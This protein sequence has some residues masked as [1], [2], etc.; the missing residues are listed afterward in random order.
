MAA[1]AHLGIG[2]AAKPLAPKVSLWVLLVA[3]ELLDILWLAFYFTGI[4]K[5]V[6]MERASPYSHGLFMSA[7]WSVIA[8]AIAGLVYRDLRSSSV[9]GLIVFSHWLLDL[10]THPMGAIFGGRVLSPDL[11]LLFSGSRRVGFG[12]YNHSY[13]LAVASDLAIFVIGFAI[14]RNYR[15]VRVGG[16]NH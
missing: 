7:L 11:P 15:K 14:Y 4:D 1:V 13:L 5:N 9:I 6:S 16:E 12:L 3:S 2:F 8:A 10:I